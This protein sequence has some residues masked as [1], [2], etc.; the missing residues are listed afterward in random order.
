M[1][2]RNFL[3]IIVSL[4]LVTVYCILLLTSCI[5]V[6]S[7]NTPN[8]PNTPG[9]NDGE[10]VVTGN[11]LYASQVK[12]DKVNKVVPASSL[13]D[14]N[15]QVYDSFRDD[16]YYYYVYY[17]GYINNVP[18]QSDYPSFD[19][20]GIK[21]TVSVET[22]EAK[23]ESV[24]KQIENIITK[25]SGWGISSKIGA[26]VE[27]KGGCI[28]GEAKMG[29]SVER[30]FSLNSS[31]IK[32]TST[33]ATDVNEFS[34]EKKHTMTIYFDETC[35]YGL[36][37]YV[38]MGTFDVY[39]IIAYDT[40]T[41]E[42][43]GETFSILD[44]KAFKLDY[45]EG[46]RFV[47]NSLDAFSP[48]DFLTTLDPNNLEI[49]EKVIDG[50]PEEVIPPVDNSPI[51][52]PLNAKNCN[53]DNGYNA[54]APSSDQNVLNHGNYVPGSYKMYGVS[55]NGSNYRINENAGKFSIQ[56][57]VE[58]SPDSLQGSGLWI[59]NDGASSAANT[60]ISSQIGEGAFWARITFKDGSS[61]L[62]F[63]KTNLLHMQNEGDVITLL[64][65][66]DFVGVDTSNIQKIE[67]SFVYEIA[68]YLGWNLFNIGSYRYS[69][70]R[71]DYTFNFV[72]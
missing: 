56:F 70:W 57:I 25:N 12:I 23:T 59:E 18:L 28:I 71:S 17:M 16:Q 52:L 40:T 49:P 54:T 37:R 24:S 48:D 15:L 6:Q 10:N 32:S 5:T 11:K 42:F 68:E 39:A 4:T 53:G 69:N 9:N 33:V 14:E 47:D 36:Y 30:G 8:T 7:P 34:I 66:D 67:I 61:Q 38:L 62:Q 27:V 46:E 3:K 44:N 51:L 63:N 26:S 43:S 58:T 21:H 72:E 20:Q 45:T 19:Y 13:E 50:T 35:P 65:Q 41:K 29:A 64:S 22:S 31:T 2:K 60:N 1:K 55:K